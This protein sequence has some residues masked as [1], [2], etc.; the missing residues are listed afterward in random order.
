MVGLDWTTRERALPTY[1]DYFAEIKKRI[2]E[3]TPQE[4]ASE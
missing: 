1:R 4:R 2:K 3:A